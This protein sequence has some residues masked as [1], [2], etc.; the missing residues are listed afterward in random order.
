MK[1]RISPLFIA[2][3]LVAGPL[4]ASERPHHPARHQAHAS[5]VVRDSPGEAFAPAVR[6][7]ADEPLA[8][9]M[10]RVRAA[11]HSL[12]QG[13]HGPLEVAQVR[14]V[15]A[16]LDAAVQEMFALCRLA[17]EPDA[18]LH[19]LLARVLQARARLAKGVFDAQAL[20]DLEVVLARY[21]LLFEDATW[22]TPIDA[23]DA[24]KSTPRAA[25]HPRSSLTTPAPAAGPAGGARAPRST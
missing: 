12:S 9:G 23:S 7:Q 18:A 5:P 3:M 10:Q 22:S 19:P 6:W 20:A 1:P 17:P 11:T 14:A 15:A 16:E 21:P 2:L 4:G 24:V 25:S 13:A 8:R